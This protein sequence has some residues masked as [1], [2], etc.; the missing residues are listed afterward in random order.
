MLVVVAV[1]VDISV[2]RL[3]TWQL[4]R[5]YDEQLGLVLLFLSDVKAQT[6][7]PPSCRCSD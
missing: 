4:T 2:D 5:L 1:D 6:L 7:G 3:V